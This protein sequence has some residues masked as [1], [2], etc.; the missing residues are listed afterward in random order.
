M[1]PSQTHAQAVGPAAPKGWWGRNWKWGAPAGLILLAV[2]AALL[3]FALV[4]S[5]IRG[6]DVYSKALERA[7]ANP[8]VVGQL[9][10]PIEAG[11]MLRGSIKSE[12]DV[13][14]AN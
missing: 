10:E 11:W 4:I 14:R 7:R 2:A 9:G 13:Q 12:G 6:S 1:D 5:P 8:Q 3:Y